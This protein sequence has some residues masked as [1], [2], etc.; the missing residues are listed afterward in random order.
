MR[1]LVLGSIAIQVS[2]WWELARESLSRRVIGSEFLSPLKSSEDEFRGDTVGKVESG[3]CWEAEAGEDPGFDEFLAEEVGVRGD[4][5]EGEEE[6]EDEEEEGAHDLPPRHKSRPDPGTHHHP[7]SSAWRGWRGGVPV[8]EE[9]ERR[10]CRLHLE[11]RNQN[12]NQ[13]YLALPNSLSQARL[14]ADADARQEPGIISSAEG[15]DL[16]PDWAK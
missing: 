15:K 13:V 4:G 14:T 5:S 1:W 11:T 7:P 16:S 10:H 2:E 12:Q 6:S 3:F 8:R 9:R